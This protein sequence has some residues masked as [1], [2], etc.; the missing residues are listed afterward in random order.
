VPGTSGNNP[1]GWID[2]CGN[3]TADGGIT[4]VNAGFLTPV[5]PQGWQANTFWSVGFRILDSNQNIECALETG[6]A[7]GNTP[8]TWKTAIGAITEDSSLQWRNGG[9]MTSHALPASGGT[10]GIIIDN[11]VGSG[12][13]AGASEVYFSTLGTGACGA[14]NGCAVQASQSALN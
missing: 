9:P 13:L 8:P 5:T 12:T 3:E 1:P 7:S 2:E 10:S 11:V 4:W 6:V 14:G